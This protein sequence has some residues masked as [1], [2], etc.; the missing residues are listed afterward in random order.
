MKSKKNLDSDYESVLNSIKEL[1]FVIDLERKI[2]GFNNMF[3]ESLSPCPKKDII[4]KDYNLLLKKY[5]GEGKLQESCEETIEDI[6]SKGKYNS[7]NEF[8]NSSD[9]TFFIANGKCGR[10]G[11]N[12]F[13]VRSFPSFGKDKKVRR[14]VCTINN[15]TQIIKMGR[16][17]QGLNEELEKKVLERTKQLKEAIELKSK[18]VADV[19]HEL[20][21]PLTIMKGNLDLLLRTKEFDDDAKEM[22]GVIEGQIDNM[23]KMLLDLATLAKGEKD[24]S[25]LRLEK[26]CIYK[27]IQNVAKIF[28][29]VAKKYKI[30]ILFSGSDDS[31]E[32]EL[33]GDKEKLERMA[34]N[35]I[36]NAIKYGKS[37][38]WVKIGVECDKSSL[39]ISV[40]DDGIGMPK[41][42]L[43]NIFDRFYRLNRLSQ[44]ENFS[45]S[46]KCSGSGL[47]LAICKWVAEA[48][49]GRIEVES[50]INRGSTF[51]VYLPIAN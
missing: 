31:K 37:N 34:S 33:L 10:E 47:G 46:E 20:R 36:S 4:N 17:L 21:T 14:I 29:A 7:E 51:R 24:I 27:L 32:I 19:S 39:T 48:H 15:V 5:W 49:K 8:I 50:E 9:P 23:A 11:E 18:F 13:K 45:Q 44:D 35:L 38:G 26:V 12:F 30:S 16:E 1:I 25:G 22:L 2:V 41:K 43:I 6:L 42:D 40:S 28:D 3:V